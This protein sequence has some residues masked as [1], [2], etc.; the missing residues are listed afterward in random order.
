MLEDKEEY[1]ANEMSSF[2]VTLALFRWI[3][4]NLKQSL[5]FTTFYKVYLYMQEA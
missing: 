4:F 1:F 5:L 2:N 3:F